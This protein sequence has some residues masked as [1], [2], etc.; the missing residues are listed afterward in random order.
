MKTVNNLKIERY[1]DKKFSEVRTRNL[2]RIIITNIH[3][4]QCSYKSIKPRMFPA[5][6]NNTCLN[7][8]G[9]RICNDTCPFAPNLCK[10]V[11]F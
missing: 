8:G 1:M 11:S 3:H 10:L 9:G 2:R 4:F 6:A 5:P 7:N